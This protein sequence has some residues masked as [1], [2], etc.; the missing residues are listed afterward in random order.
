MTSRSPGEPRQV[1]VS[2]PATSA[3][4][5]PGYD[6]LGLAL[7]L[8]DDVIV[9]MVAA[10]T[11][12]A[13]TISVDVSGESAD[14]VPRDH[15][16]LI[17]RT[18]RDVFERIGFPQPCLTIGTVNAIP[19][20]RGLGSSAAAIVAGV[21]AAFGLSEPSAPLDRERILQVAAELEGH[22]D[23]VA[24]CV[25]GGLT[26]AWTDHC[27]TAHAVVLEPIG[28]RPVVVVPR[29][30][31]ATRAAR[32][33]LPATVAHAVAAGNVARAALLVAVLTG[34]APPDHLLTATED[35]LHQP[36]R[37]GAMPIAS[38]LLAELRA[39]GVPTVVSGAGP[40]LLTFIR[41]EA[42]LERCVAT[43]DGRAQVLALDVDRQGV[44]VE[45]AV[46]NVGESRA[47]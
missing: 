15:T 13:P 20:G 45:A 29:E 41:T 2:V 16:H 33:L 1:R 27:G 35:G 8:R 12:S 6:T 38:A 30:Q 11:K 28:W 19:H 3:N 46:P 21:A 18:V 5:G 42:E 37:A 9:A 36:F 10:D 23:N 47:R 25:F 22:P 14:D 4:L 32:A 24:P 44:S 34:Q 17:A 39:A 43:V 26:V 31:L 7:D 40:S